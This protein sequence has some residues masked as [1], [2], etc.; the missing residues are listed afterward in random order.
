MLPEALANR[1][2]SLRPGEERLAVTVEMELDGAEAVSTV[3]HRSRIR[4]DKR[5]DLRR[6]GR[7]LRRPGV[8]WW[9]LGAA[10]GRRARSGGG[11]AGEA[12]CLELGALELV[13]EWDSDGHVTG[14]RYEQQTESHSLIEQLMILA[15]EQVAGYLADRKQPTSTGCTSGLSRRRWRSSWSSSRAWTSPRRR[16]RAT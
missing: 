2:C 9:R 1:A 5:D 7:D 3:F 11:A 6:G 8:G 10:A 13:F 4:S 15:N 14:V 12:R 16:C